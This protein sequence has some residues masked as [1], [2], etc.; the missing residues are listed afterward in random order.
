MTIRELHYVLRFFKEK[1]AMGFI[2]DFRQ[3]NVSEYQPV[4]MLINLK[5]K[6]F[7]MIFE[8]E[9]KLHAILEKVEIIEKSEEPYSDVMGKP[10]VI[11]SLRTKKRRI[12]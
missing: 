2:S 12:E 10:C 3:M 6:P 5:E 9:I 8:P 1:V 4:Y 7:R 11:V